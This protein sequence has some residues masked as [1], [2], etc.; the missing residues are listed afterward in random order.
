[1]TVN[2]AMRMYRTTGMG[3]AGWLLCAAAVLAAEPPSESSEHKPDLSEYTLDLSD[4]DYEHW[5][6]LPIAQSQPPQVE[7][8]HN[9][10][11][12]EI[13]TF[14]LSRLSEEGLQ[15][16]P[17]ADDRTWLRRVYF[18]LIGLPPAPAEVSS[19][20]ADKSPDKREQLVD[21]LLADPGYGVRWG[22]RWLDVVRYADTNGYERDGD[23]PHAWRYR[24]YVIESLNAD[25]PFDRFLTEQLAGDELPHANAETMIATTFLRL[26]TWDDEPADPRI[27][28]YDQLDDI[29]GTVSSTFLGLTLRCARCHNHK[30][31][32]FS[33]TDY[34]GMLAIFEPLKRPQ[35]NRTDLDVLVGT[36]RELSAY[37][38]AVARYET[39]LKTLN[40]QIN[41]LDDHV[42]ERFLSEGKSELSAAAI[43]AHRTAAD[44]LTDEQKKLVKQT[45]R[46]LKK[47]LIASRTPDEQRQR[48]AFRAAITAIEA[49]KPVSPP[50][51]YIWQEPAENVPV[52]HVF[53]RGDPA[54]PIAPV[55]PGFPGVLQASHT[56]LLNP[57][58]SDR[59]TLR[60]RSLAQWMTSPT[61]PLVARVAVNRI[62]QGHFGEGLVRT[63]NDFGVMGMP[64]SHPQLLDWLARH[65]IESGW[66]LKQLHRLIVLSSTYGQAGLHREDAAQKDIDNEWL[67]R[68]PSTRLEAEVLRDSVLSVSG[69]LNLKMGGPGVYAKI[70]PEVLAGQ[71]RPGSGWGKWDESEASRRAAYIFVKRSL[72]VPLLEVF[73]LA[74]T[75]Q[76]C[77]QR[78]RSTIPTQALTLLN[79]E[80]LN[81]QAG[82][83]ADRLKTEAGNAAPAQVDLAFRLALSR[84]PL[85]QELDASIGFLNRQHLL[86]E[87][88]KPQADEEEI[89]REALQAFCLAIFNLNEFLYID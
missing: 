79:S 52:T 86:I 35:D 59:T 74:D 40:D 27:D 58:E 47:E 23:K 12:N 49:T 61:N 76:S 43:E 87:R 33:Q 21:R 50:K 69:Q 14:I 1:M 20:L 48:E 17:P 54:T 32:P 41:S 81:R 83:F 5:A 89:H 57:T 63:E 7:D 46:Q 30:Y 31:E 42:R 80:F 56:P 66:N 24:D 68:F 60:R 77:E 4:G 73:D 37:H 26:G 29:V 67:W 45:L 28:R 55:P 15:P 70:A 65:F 64:P 13:D 18:D 53:G 44:K 82:Y 6:F 72:L 38:S 2:V 88:E 62:W 16:A 78:N 9:W 8:A 3:V 36:R 34:A 11:R 25:K 75:T 71:S 51:A 22:R 10:V 85:E 39:T 84:P 19:F